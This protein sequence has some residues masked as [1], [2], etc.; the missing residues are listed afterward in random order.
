MTESARELRFLGAALALAGLVLLAQLVGWRV[1]DALADE[2]TRRELTETC[3]RE[4]KGLT[5]A[6]PRRD[7]IAATA[8]GGAV[9]TVVETNRVTIVFAP[10]EEEAERVA[11]AYR[12][13]GGPLVGRLEIRESTVYFWAR[14]ASPTQRQ[15]LYDCQY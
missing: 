11:A 7:P 10:H 6:P 13:V 15:Q 1:H 12:A 9:S 8:A 4:E 3:L 14:P 5:L 2:P